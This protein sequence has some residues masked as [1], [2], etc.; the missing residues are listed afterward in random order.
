MD[1]LYLLIFLVAMTYSF[2][3][4]G[5]A[6][7]YLAVLAL[8]G[9][10]PHKMAQSVLVLNLLVSAT[11]LW[12][13]SRAGY[14]KPKLLRPFALASVPAAFIGGMLNVPYE[15]YTRLFSGALIFAAFRLALAGTEKPAEKNDAPRLPSPAISLAAGA[16]IGFLSGIIGIGGGIFL[17]PLLILMRWA[18]VKRTAAV[19]AAFILVNSFAGLCGHVFHK[20][21]EVMEIWPLVFIAFLGGLAGSYLGAHRAGRTALCR[22]LAGVLA[23]AAFKMIIK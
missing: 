12:S 13:Y 15:F 8:F 19:S 14:F 5:G 18:D 7:G 23:V 2:V 22:V 20:G 4:H 17:S 1:I 6:S 3:G 9:F 10:A 21:I 16:G 11:A